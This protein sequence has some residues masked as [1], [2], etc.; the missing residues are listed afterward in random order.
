MPAPAHPSDFGATDEAYRVSESDDYFKRHLSKAGVNEWAHQERYSFVDT[1]QV[2]RENQDVVYSSSVVD[3]SAG[4]TISVPEY[5]AYSIVQIIDQQNYSLHTVYR[6]ESHTI[7]PDDVSYGSH[8]YLNARTQP[9][10]LG[11]AGFADV[12]R[13]QQQLVI[14]APSAKPYES[15]DILLDN[16]VMLEI[17]AALV[18][19]VAK[20]MV[21]DFTVLMGAKGDVDR[22]GHLYATAYGWGGL[23]TADAAYFSIPNADAESDAWEVVIDPPPLDATRGG[24]WS[25]TAY[26]EEGWLAYDKAAISNIE[27]EPNEDGTFT[28]R[29][30]Q[31]GKPNNLEIGSSFAAL[32]RF[33]V[34]TS[35]DAARSYLAN[36][37]QHYQVIPAH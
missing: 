7:R 9:T 28:V 6:G 14:D 1:Q 20:G 15:P 16:R 29:F 24:F 32:L 19:D 22:Q 31:T 3:V 17:R 36:G 2:I 11:D 26:N 34:P 33:Y 5:P 27:A 13:H 18:G 12:H 4:A 8:V 21:K 10:A 35:I 30:G 37:Q 23:P 25:I